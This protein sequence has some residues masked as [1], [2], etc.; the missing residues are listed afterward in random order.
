MADVKAV[1]L[2]DRLRWTNDD[3][4]IVEFDDDGQA[5]KGV[6]V[7]IPSGEFDRLEKVGAV[8]KPKSK[9]A[10]AAK[11]AADDA[12]PEAAADES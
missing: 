9:D 5:A 10:K 12:P 8:A 4:V 6:E 1:S 11:D 7:S 3:G 2:V